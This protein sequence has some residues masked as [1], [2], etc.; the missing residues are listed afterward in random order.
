MANEIG[1]LM[2]IAGIFLV[3]IGAIIFFA[4]KIPFVGKLPGD[5]VVRRKSFTLYLPIAT[6]VL[7][8][9]LLTLLFR[10]ILRK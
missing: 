3:L 6:C 9:I 10:F 4:D 5:I 2:I 8:S 1:R 7:L